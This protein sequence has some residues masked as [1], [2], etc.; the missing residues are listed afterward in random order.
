MGSRC[1]LPE[2][3][4]PHVFGLLPSCLFFPPRHPAHVHG[5]R[6]RGEV[7]Q[8]LRPPWVKGVGR[9]IWNFHLSL[10]CSEGPLS[11]WNGPCRLTLDVI[12]G[13]SYL[14]KFPGVQK[15]GGPGTLKGPLE[16]WLSTTSRGSVWEDSVDPGGS[17]AS[18]NTHV[19][20]G[21]PP[22]QRS[23][24]CGRCTFSFLY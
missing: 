18:P 5:P 16:S 7:W 10:I 17:T 2:A 6:R 22:Q 4:L 21:A 1:A 14:G 23:L 15:L 13:H 20:P 9:D 8:L 24:L 19:C 3:N 12:G 11:T